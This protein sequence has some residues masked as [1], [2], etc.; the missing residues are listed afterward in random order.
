GELD[1]DHLQAVLLSLA[2]QMP[3]LVEE[4]E[5][6]IGL[7][8]V[9]ESLPPP[10]KPVE[11]RARRT[12]IDSAAIRQQVRGALHGLNRRSRS[13]A[14]DQVSAVLSHVGQLVGQAWE[15]TQA[16]DGRTALAIL[17]AITEEYMDG[18]ETVY[19]DEGEALG[20]F[21]SIGEAWTEALLTA[22]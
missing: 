5:R 1:R 2:G 22:D 7:T 17:E 20:Y 3:T 19:D 6:A 10:G 4:I 9:V 12:P 16:G 14:Y 11:M 21:E 15:F 8:R 13:E 18:W